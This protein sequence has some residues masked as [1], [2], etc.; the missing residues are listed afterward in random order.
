[1]IVH[2]THVHPHRRIFANRTLDLRGVKAIGYDLDYTLV[3]YKVRA[4]EGR[5]Y[6]HLQRRL[7]ER[8]WPVEHLA[9]DPG[10]VMR[11]LVID[12]ERGNLLKV[13]R[14]GYVKAALHGTERMPW[15]QT[16]ATY[17]RTVVDL[18]D[19]RWD[20]ANTLFSLS[21]ASSL[22]WKRNRT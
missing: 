2:P 16:R 3:H 4:W 17:A 22:G 20:F 6:E 13:N 7:V 15:E 19:R 18:A 14:F 5:A 11:G 9:F 21:E 8:G 1:M 12:T 10:L